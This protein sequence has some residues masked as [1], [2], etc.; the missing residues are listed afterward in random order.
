MTILSGDYF[1]VEPGIVALLETEFPDIEVRAPASLGEL[2]EQSQGDL[3]LYLLYAGDLVVAQSS[4]G[5]Q[6]QV[7]QQWM[8][9]LSVRNASAQLDSSRSRAA[10][11]PLIARL[12]RCLMG[13]E[14]SAF[15]GPL[16]RGSGQAAGYSSSFAYFPFMFKTRVV[17]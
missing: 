14:P 13:R 5:E 12:L 9:V 10:A 3:N 8:V 2:Q 7:D 4:D 15:S 11:G 17:T 1:E 16:I 6:V